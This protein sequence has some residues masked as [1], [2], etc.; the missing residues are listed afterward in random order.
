M[1]L[2][3]PGKNTKV[4]ALYERMQIELFNLLVKGVQLDRK[5]LHENNEGLD[6]V[7][8]AIPKQILSMGSN[9]WNS[10][11]EEQKRRYLFSKIKPLYLEFSRKYSS[12]LEQMRGVKIDDLDEEYGYIMSGRVIKSSDPYVNSLL[13]VTS[14]IRN[15]IFNSMQL[16]HKEETYIDDIKDLGVSPVIQYNIYS[17]VV[18]VPRN[19]SE[20]YAAI[21]EFNHDWQKEIS[22]KAYSGEVINRLLDDF[23]AGEGED[24]NLNKQNFWGKLLQAGYAKVVLDLFEDIY[25]KNIDLKISEKFLNTVIRTEMVRNFASSVIDNKY[26]LDAS[27]DD[28]MRQF[29]KALREAGN[30]IDV[31]RDFERLCRKKRAYDDLN[32]FHYLSKEE[33]PKML[34]NN[35]DVEARGDSW[36]NKVTSSNL[37]GNIR[38]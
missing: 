6:K 16:Y 37:S 21:R 10:I 27:L 25:F 19:I 1:D 36:S 2:Q 33:L 9:E 29:I 18:G 26:K 8:K 5:S 38:R 15:S 34:E 12:L 22:L 35:K 4:E 32:V 3:N 13:D 17:N 24:N 31:Y 7:I 11:E 20:F 23:V 14:S 28:Q 30:K